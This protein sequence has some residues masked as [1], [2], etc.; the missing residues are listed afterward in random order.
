MD[1]E[2]KKKD[3]FGSFSGT[4]S[5]LYRTTRTI[6]FDQQNQKLNDDV[7]LTN[8]NSNSNENLL[9]KKIEYSL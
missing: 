6:A 8:V 5:N 3:S 4:I 2:N 9:L 7:G 1:D